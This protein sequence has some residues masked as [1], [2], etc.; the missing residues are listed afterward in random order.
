MKD[1]RTGWKSA[2]WWGRRPV[3][4][5]GQDSVPPRRGGYSHSGSGRGVP[6]HGRWR[7]AHDASTAA[8]RRADLSEGGRAALRRAPKEGSQAANL[9]GTR[10]AEAWRAPADMKRARLG[11]ARLGSARLGSARLGSARLGSARL[12]SA[13][14]GSALNYTQPL[15]PEAAQDRP[16]PRPDP[17]T[18]APVPRAP[19]LPRRP[20]RPGVAHRCRHFPSRARLRPSEPWPRLSL[21]VP[22][23][24]SHPGGPG[25][26]PALRGGAWPQRDA[27]HGSILDQTKYLIHI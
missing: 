6:G 11:S 22:S 8:R 5:H 19:A 2:S 27:R 21:H 3:W 13:R 9:T 25:I 26:R 24:A 18:R 20:A 16:A 15:G 1:G 17:R 12:G 10:S 14:L 23:P 4:Q 7:Q